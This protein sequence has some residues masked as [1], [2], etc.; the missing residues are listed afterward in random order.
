MVA[1]SR[2]LSWVNPSGEVQ[3]N[4]FALQMDR[5]ERSGTVNESLELP[6]PHDSQ[7]SIEENRRTITVTC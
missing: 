7:T 5:A 4:S 6:L 2:D 3:L 1:R